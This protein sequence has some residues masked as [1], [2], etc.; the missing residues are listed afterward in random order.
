M[1]KVKE[2]YLELNPAAAIEIQQS[3]S[4]TGMT[5]TI[6]NI[7][8]LDVASRRLKDSELKF[9]LKPIEIAMD[10]IAVIVNRENE[11][12]GASLHSGP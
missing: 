3:D 5:S 7:C 6:S 8:D 11:R 1:E 4:S 2:A 12:A 9:G 10:G